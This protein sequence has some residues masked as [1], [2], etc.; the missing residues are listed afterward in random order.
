MFSYSGR[1]RFLIQKASFD[2]FS[3][4]VDT[5]KK[6]KIE[7][8]ILYIGKSNK[9]RKKEKNNSE[10]RGF[11]H[12]NSLY[13]YVFLCILLAL[14]D[15]FMQKTGFLYIFPSDKHRN[16]VLEKQIAQFAKIIVAQFAE[17]VKMNHHD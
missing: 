5:K 11:R 16:R 1:Y 12:F 3:V 7:S 4:V 2:T 14:N 10:N 6:N 13:F 9:K 8:L 15:V 17:S